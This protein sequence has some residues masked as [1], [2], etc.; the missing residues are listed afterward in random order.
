MEH[1]ELGDRVEGLVTRLVNEHA[2]VGDR[3]HHILLNVVTNET[4]SSRF[5]D[6]RR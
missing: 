3:R 2:L 5:V 4:V 6:V 1:G